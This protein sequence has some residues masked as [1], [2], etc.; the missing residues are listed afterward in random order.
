M[1]H[2][3]IQGRVPLLPVSVQAGFSSYYF[4][5]LED[6]VIH[7]PCPLEYQRANI[8]FSV[9]GRSMEP[10]FFEEDILFCAELSRA[11]WPYLPLRASD[12]YV[13]HYGDNFLA[14]KYLKKN[15]TLGCFQLLS[16]NRKEF[17]PEYVRFEELRN[18]WKV[19]GKQA[20]S[21]YWQKNC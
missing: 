19:L 4:D 18:I 5:S 12:A 2:K 1:L 13:L 3:S 14:L 20:Q 21:S 9:V 10:D 17:P 16:A 15:E 11:D 7:I 6:E 8:A